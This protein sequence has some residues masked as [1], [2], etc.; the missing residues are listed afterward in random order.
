MKMHYNRGDKQFRQA[1]IA[2]RNVMQHCPWQRKAVSDY[3]WGEDKYGG[4][5]TN[6]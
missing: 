3:K 4:T 2:P 1:G 5:K 6:R